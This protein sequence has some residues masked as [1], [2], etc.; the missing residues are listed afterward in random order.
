VKY[1]KDLLADN[2]QLL[3]KFRAARVYCKERGWD[4]KIYDEHRIRTTR[5]ANIQFLW[6]YKSSTRGEGYYGPI[7]DALLDLKEPTTMLELLESMYPGSRER[8]EAI[9]VWWTMVV[10]GA[11]KCDLDKPLKK[12]TLF[13]VEDSRKERLRMKEC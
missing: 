10:G 2:E 5:L 12:S 8:G 6:R 7:M 9:W 13:W 3:P 1:R 4:F 11:I